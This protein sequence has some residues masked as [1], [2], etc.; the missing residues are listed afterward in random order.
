MFTPTRANLPKIL[1]RMR[2]AVASLTVIQ[3]Q[4]VY[5]NVVKG[6]PIS[7]V[8]RQLGLSRNAADRIASVARVRIYAAAVA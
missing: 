6:W 4:A 3:Q 7:R 5:L 8:A 2:R 1:D